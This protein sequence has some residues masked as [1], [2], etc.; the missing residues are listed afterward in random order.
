LI[1]LARAEVGK[2]FLELPPAPGR[3]AVQALHAR[4]REKFRQLALDLLRPLADVVKVLA[5]AHRT[6]SG[7]DGRVAAVVAHQAMLATVIGERD[8]TVHASDRLATAPAEQVPGVAAPVEQDHG[9]R[10]GAHLGFDLLLEPPRDRHH[11]VGLAEFLA[12]VHNL[13]AGQRASGDSLFQHGELVFALAGIPAGLERRSRR[14]QEGQRLRQSRPHYGYVP[15]VVARGLLLLVA[16][17]VLLV[18]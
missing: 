7:H 13:D 9:L 8:G 11:R 14:T 5:V 15:A 2:D 1:D 12:H 17:L 10:P 18:D 3:V 16:G 4:P 6:A